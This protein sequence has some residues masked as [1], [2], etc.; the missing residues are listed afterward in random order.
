M[1]DGK[2]V[3]NNNKQFKEV[4][5]IISGHSS[6]GGAAAPPLEFGN[7]CPLLKDE[8]MTPGTI[9]LTLS[10]EIIITTVLHIKSIYIDESIQFNHL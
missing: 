4:F 6:P 9:S 5:Y 7:H 3:L 1:S 8:M 2:M 10:P